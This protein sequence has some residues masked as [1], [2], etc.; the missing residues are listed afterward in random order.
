MNATLPSKKL[1]QRR[2]NRHSATT[3]NLDFFNLLTSPA[4]FEQDGSRRRV[5]DFRRGH[6]LGC[7]DHVI[8]IDKPATKP[9]WMSDEDYTNAPDHIT[10][11]ECQ[12]AG[13]ILVTTICDASVSKSELGALYKRRWDKKYV[14]LSL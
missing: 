11:R 3:D 7:R 13:R 10:V 9:D 6:R 12:T 14:A 5:T 8:R 2:V 4:L 1:Q